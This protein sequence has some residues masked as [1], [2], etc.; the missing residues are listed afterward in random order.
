MWGGHYHWHFHHSSVANSTMVE[1]ELC[2]DNMELDLGTVNVQGGMNQL[3]TQQGRKRKDPPEQQEQDESSNTHPKEHH[4][5]AFLCGFVCTKCNTGVGSSLFGSLTDKVIKG[6]FTTG[7]C[8]SGQGKPKY[9]Q[10]A[11]DLTIAQKALHESVKSNPSLALDLISKTFPPDLTQSIPKA[12]YC[13]NCGY[14]DT[15]SSRMDI[16]FNQSDGSRNK[17]NCHHHLHKSEG[18]I[19]KGLY[20]LHCPDQTLKSICA[21]TFKLPVPTSDKSK[22]PNLHMFSAPNLLEYTPASSSDS[23]S[24]NNSTATTTSEHES[25]SPNL[26]NEKFCF[27]SSND[28]L[29]CALNQVNIAC[30]D[31]QR[32]C[33]VFMH[34]LSINHQQNNK[35]KM[36]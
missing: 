20:N 3:L 22:T 17:F 31:N 10:I 34:A 30:N 12:H 13:Q 7:K 1:A 35:Q 6:H 8:Y 25:T 2:V 29:Q 14:W 27:K 26:L 36:N 19:C 4:L 33:S 18:I 28:Q 23:I 24:N 5:V 15:K 9:T 11:K 16:H 32:I 21:G